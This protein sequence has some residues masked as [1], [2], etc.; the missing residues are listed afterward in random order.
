MAPD[1][2]ALSV[3]ANRAPA[4]TTLQTQGQP[5][6]RLQGQAEHVR[7]LPVPPAPHVSQ[8]GHRRRVGGRGWF[9]LLRRGWPQRDESRHAV[10]GEVNVAALRRHLLDVIDL[11]LVAGKQ[12]QWIGVEVAVGRVYGYTVDSLSTR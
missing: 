5:G 1:E 11:Y 7:P 3:P 2:G 10:G 4:S 9:A 8:K 12:R 6:H